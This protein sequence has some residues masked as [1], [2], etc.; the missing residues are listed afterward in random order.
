MLEFVEK[1]LRKK[2]KPK[3]NSYIETGSW[4]TKRDN[5]GRK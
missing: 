5:K 1:H 2:S 3:E 4:E